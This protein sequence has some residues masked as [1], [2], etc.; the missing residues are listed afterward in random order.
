MYRQ[1]WNTW[2][3]SQ[4]ATIF[5][6]Q[7]RNVPLSPNR[8]HDAPGKA[9]FIVKMACRYATTPSI[10]PFF[11]KH[12]F[13][14]TYLYIFLTFS[15]NFLSLLFAFSPHFFVFVSSFVILFDFACSFLFLLLSHLSGFIAFFLFSRKKKKRFYIYLQSHFWKTYFNVYCY[16]YNFHSFVLSL[17]SSTYSCR[18]IIHS[19]PLRLLLFHTFVSNFHIF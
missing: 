4:F 19:L 12:S 6:S 10:H 5:Q 3:R 17:M 11:R 15:F 2:K 8:I 9:V 16:K 1:I 18:L 14:K 13:V 7:E